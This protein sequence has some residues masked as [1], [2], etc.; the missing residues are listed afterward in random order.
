M[1]SVCSV[2]VLYPNNRRDWY[3]I[4]RDPRKNFTLPIAPKP[5][6]SILPVNG[7]QWRQSIFRMF[8]KLFTFLLIPLLRVHG[9]CPTNTLRIPSILLAC[10]AL[11]MLVKLEM[12]E[13]YV[14]PGCGGWLRN[15]SQKTCK[16]NRAKIHKEGLWIFMICPCSDF[17]C[18]RPSQKL[19]HHHHH[20]RSA[21]VWRDGSNLILIDA[22]HNSTSLSWE[23]FLVRSYFVAMVSPSPC[24]PMSH[25][26]NVYARDCWHL[27]QSASAWMDGVEWEPSRKIYLFSTTI[28]VLVPPFSL[29]KINVANT[30]FLHACTSSSPRWWLASVEICWASSSSFSLPS[31]FPA[32]TG[33]I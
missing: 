33:I 18:V 31:G 17:R 11:G 4:V 26:L 8:C 2:Y 25:A 24:L 23:V 21:P 9:A 7:Q 22:G 19:A 15:S 27:F 10:D 13:D 5:W 29:I 14:S 32:T 6:H 30:N 28:S 20:H 1:L 3:G 16:K 12:I